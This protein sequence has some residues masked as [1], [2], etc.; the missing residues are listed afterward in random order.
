MIKVNCK[1][2]LYL[3]SF[4][5]A[6]FVALQ[7]LAWATCTCTWLPFWGKVGAVQTMWLNLW[8]PDQTA[9]PQDK[10]SIANLQKLYL[11]SDRDEIF[12]G[13]QYLVW[14]TCICTF[15]G[16]VG[17]VFTMWINLLMQNQVVQ[18]HDKNQ[19]RITPRPKILGLSWFDF[20]LCGSTTWFYINRWSHAVHTSPTFPQLHLCQI[21]RYAMYCSSNLYVHIVA[22]QVQEQGAEAKCQEPK[23]K[24]RWA[25]SDQGICWNIAPLNFQRN[26]AKPT[27]FFVCPP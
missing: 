15:W 25:H 14:P 10:K 22:I 19:I 21:R 20:L 7:Y 4:R 26:D 6:T 23:W 16:K 12:V 2:K 5:N 17:E 11:C 9:Q 8:M 18:P 13:L 3:C 27:P 24:L 1:R